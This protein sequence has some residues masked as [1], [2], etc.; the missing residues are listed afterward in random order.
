MLKTIDLLKS[1]T[2]RGLAV[3][4]IAYLIQIFNLSEV[5]PDGA[6][7]VVDG[8]FKLV[9]ILGMVYAAIKRT[10]APNPPLTV[11]AVEKEKMMLAEGKIE[12]RS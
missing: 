5:F 8:L 9:A 6:E 3:A 12:V 10:F 1:G 2:L 11:T 7:S 4:L